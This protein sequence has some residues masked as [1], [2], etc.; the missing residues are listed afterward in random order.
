[1]V[2]VDKT[3]IR[4]AGTPKK[5]TEEQID[6][7]V[8]KYNDGMPAAQIAKLYDVTPPTIRRYLKQRM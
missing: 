1:M 8:T 6:E 4:K 3:K 7:V 2:K 5:L